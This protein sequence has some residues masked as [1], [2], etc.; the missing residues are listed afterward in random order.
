MLDWMKKLFNKEEEQTALNKEVQ[1]QIESQPKIPR[2]NHYT[3]AREAQMASRNAGKCRFPLVP[4]NGFDEEDEREVDRF[5]EQPVQGVTYEEPTAQRGIQVERSRRP[6]VE[7]VVSTYEEPEVQ[8]E[9]V[10]E[11]V[12]KK[13]SAPSQESNRR[14]FRP[15]EMISPI[16]GYNRPSVEKKVEKQ[17]EVKEREDLEISVEG[18]AVVDAWLEKKGYTLSD[19]SEGQATSSSPSHESVGQQ[20][21]K[22]EKSVVDQWLEKNGYEIERQEPLVEEKEVIQGMSTP[23]EVSADEL[24]H[25]TVAEQMESAKLEKDVVVLNENNLQEELVASKV[26]HEDTILSEEIKRNTEI[27]QPTIEVEKQAPE[28][29]VIVKAEEKLEETIIVEIPEEL[30]EVEV[31]T[32]TEELEEVEVIAETEEPEEV[33]AETEESEEVEVI[34]ETEELEEVEV[35]AETEESE[36]VEVIAETEELEEVEVI[37]ETEE[38]EEVEVI[39]E[40]EE[41]EEVEVIAETEESEEVEVIAE[42]EESE[43]VEVIAETEESEEVEVIVETEELEEVEV[44]A[45]TEESEE[46]EVIAETEESEEV[47]VIAEAEESEEVE[48]I[49]ETEE[50]EEVEVIAETEELEEVE[51]I[52]ETEELEEVEVIAETEE[53]EEVEVIAETE[54][55]EEVEVIAETKAPVVETFV[56]LEEIQQEDEVIEQKSEFIHVAEADEQTKND[57]QSFANVLIAETE[58][59]KRVEEE[60]PV[61]EEQ[62]VEEEVPVV[63]EQPVVKKEEPKREK[64][65]HVPF[66]VV[67]L[68][69]DRTR[70]MERHAARA[71]AMQPSANVRVENKPVQQE[72]AEPQVEEQPMQQVVVESQVEEQ[73]M[74]QVVVE[75]QVEEQSVQQVVAEPQVEEQ[76]MQQ[77]V[78]EQVQ[79]P[80]SST[81]VQEKA[82]VVN[83]RE[84]DMRNVLHTP[85]TYTV[86]PL[87]LLSIPQQSALDN[88]EWLEEQKELLDTTFN[89]FHVGAHVINVSQGPAVTRFEV[90]PDPG[91]KVNKITNLSD[92]IKLSLAAKDIRIEA[93]IPGKSAIGIEVPNKESKPVFLREILRSPV[94]TKSES[95]LTVALGLDISGDPIVTDIRKMPHGLIAGATGSGKSVCINAILTSILYKAKPHEVKLM[96]IDPKMVELA[97]Y[98]SV[99]HLVAP[100]ITDVKAATAALKWAVEEMERRYELF[101]HA[102]ARDLTR[103]NTI[104]S[105]REIPGETLPYI[106]I[107]I[108]EL[109]DLMMVAPGDVEEAICRIAQ[110]ARACG[111]HL[112][113]ATQRPSVDV[114][115]G[116]IKSNIPTRIAFTVS[117]QV[118]S[119]TIIDIGGAEKLLGRG[120]MLFL[121]NGT[122]KPV[123]VQGVYVSDDEIEKTVDHVRKQMK[124][125]Y[126]FKQEDLLAKTEQAE[127]E[128]E[129]FFEA[130]QFVVEQGGASTSSVQ[131]KFRIG[132]NRAARLIEEMQSQGIISEARGTK[133][134]DVLISEDEFAAMQETNV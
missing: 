132:Y 84:N 33:I 39:A 76:P 133:P 46:V 13:A 97:P 5:E 77:V 123:R 42:T 3:E 67:M 111:I 91:V 26:E 121:G 120:D 95:P 103:Y 68:K 1:K 129:L 73:P 50:L 10:R 61:V 7:K 36:E 19:F 12:V 126:L 101:A 92:D 86:P 115:T 28:E 108:D 79:K 54:E 96:L 80:I 44:I 71:N 6:Y 32:E 72:V 127:S 110:K 128:D 69:Q 16:Y 104:V 37:A 122:S 30:E 109:A 43:E 119:R 45:E 116:L 78:V 85:P 125:N 2:V 106:V 90:Q 11:A 48:V 124:P 55:L 22:Q 20:D 35:I 40:T 89:N 93:P 15:T 113:V 118:D 94:F 75:S 25:K 27:K 66:N 70:L 114:I 34:A 52:A 82:Y 23:Q 99:P 4:D 98:N 31:I 131:R 59:N 56:A 81:E 49:A 64:K 130:C 8:Y 17:E 134:R 100:V 112:L 74:Q 53:L 107:V 21:K 60:A 14:P 38:S 41:S 9:P 62:S 83:Q 88:T 29:S 58:E 105:E 24:L 87:A 117:S 51:V 102:G 18:K 47:E 63:E 57:V 65:R